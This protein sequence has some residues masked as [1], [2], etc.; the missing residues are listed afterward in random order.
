MSQF[1][2]RYGALWIVFVLLVSIGVLGL[3]TIE[4]WKIKTTEYYGLQ[5]LG[6]TYFLVILLFF[7]LPA[8]VLYFVTVFP[9]SVL[10]RKR[11]H[12]LFWIRMV[13]FCV[14]GAVWGKFIFQKQYSNFIEGYGYELTDLTAIIIFGICGLVYSLLDSY[15]VRHKGIS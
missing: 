9:L 15:L 3:E 6:H 2:K 13:I 4:G 7:S 11:T 5:N 1:A 12:M 8:S 10:L 14:L